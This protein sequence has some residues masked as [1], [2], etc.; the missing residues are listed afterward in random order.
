MRKMRKELSRTVLWCLERNTFTITEIAEEFGISVS[1]VAGQVRTL[2]SLSLVEHV[3]TEG[4]GHAYR[5][6]IRDKERAHALASQELTDFGWR[7]WERKK[8][9]R[10]REKP[11]KLVNSVWA[12]AA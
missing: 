3:T 1:A 10:E 2:K 11:R 12:L 8:K 4:M 5:Y 7:A 6:E 9:Q